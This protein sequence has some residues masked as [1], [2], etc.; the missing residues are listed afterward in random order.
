[1]TYKLL[2]FVLIL[3]WC[4][5]IS[6]QNIPL[7]NKG[8]TTLHLQTDKQKYLPEE[9]VWFKCYLMQAGMP[10][11]N[12]THLFTTLVDASGKKIS[13]GVWPINASVANGQ[14]ALPIKGEAQWFT[15]Y[16]NAGNDIID[17][18]PVYS[19][20]FYFSGAPS[21]ILPNK[22][23]VTNA[24]QFFAESG[25]CIA[26]TVNT[27]AFSCTNN[28]GL[29]QQMQ[30]VIKNSQQ[31]VI[32]SFFTEHDGMGAIQLYAQANEIYTA[33]WYDVNGVLK[34]TILPQVQNTG[35]IL[36]AE[37][38]QQQVLYLI[39]AAGENEKPGKLYIEA[40]QNNTILYTAEATLSNTMMLTGT[41][42][43]QN[44][45]SGIV[46][47]TVF[48]AQK[49]PLAERVIFIHNTAGF[50][51]SNI[52][53]NSK[54][55]KPKGKNEFAISI[56]DTLTASVAIAVTDANFNNIAATQSIFSDMY[57]GA[58]LKGYIHQP[59]YY[60]ADTQSAT[61]RH[62]DILLQT[63]GWR[64][65]VQPQNKQIEQYI[66]IKG[67]LIDKAGKGVKN[68]PIVLLLQSADS[69]KQ[70]AFPVTDKNGQFEINNLVFFDTIKC[71]YKVK[72]DI[73]YQ[74]N[75]VLNNDIGLTPATQKSIILLAPLPQQQIELMASNT[76][77]SMYFQALEKNKVGFEK[78]GKLLKEIKVKSKKAW[79]KDPLYIIDQK[80]TTGLF[81]GGATTYS[82]D[83]LKD[84][85]ATAKF[86]IYNYLA[87]KIPRLSIVTKQL[88]KEFRYQNLLSSSSTPL[89]YINESLVDN[90]QLQNVRM[91]DI[92][93]AKLIPNFMGMRDDAGGISAA[94]AIYL[95]KFGDYSTAEL[96]QNGINT[97]NRKTLV[98]YT[99][100]KEFYVPDYTVDANPEI[101]DTRTTLYWQPDIITNAKNNTINVLFYNNSICSKY[102]IIVTGMNELGQ[103]LYAEYL[104]E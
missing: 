84:S 101:V 49:H 40:T 54:A 100:T 19:T 79:Y 71:Y 30:G 36:H 61:K 74:Y 78:E 29:P 18:L 88:G 52:V 66:T 76:I 68:I 96:K 80:Y 75:I 44:F 22:N 77:D 31:E 1:M 102:K 5:N 9:T 58:Q 73:D 13:S 51:K 35:V 7:P 50:I 33:E 70:W 69:S 48:N 2:F 55:I 24:M 37:Q 47:L 90:E 26:N 10:T 53:V 46:Q 87:F 42:P 67:K 89:I 14:I 3:L 12:I 56:A 8:Y 93:Y 99:T 41:I 39:K 63:H 28:S 97:F 43:A 86:D 15:L 25:Q 64:R 98:G 62:L 60:F 27:I 16:A 83:V 65:Y 92:A 104:V 57:F 91:E 59:A 11:D 94:I 21:S 23:M 6:A 17:S 4:K 81:S 45:N 38:M 20:R 95:K 82:F 32:D 85:T 34:K 72:S 103:L